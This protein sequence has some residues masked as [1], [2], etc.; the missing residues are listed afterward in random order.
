[1]LGVKRGLGLEE[2]GIG[3][4]CERRDGYTC[5]QLDKRHSR[6]RQLASSNGAVSENLI[7]LAYA[8]LR[9]SQLSLALIVPAAGAGEPLI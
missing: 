2:G 8:S 3:E 9:L 6:N 5:D 7:G 4:G 1:M